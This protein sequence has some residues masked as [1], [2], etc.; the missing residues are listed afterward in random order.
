MEVKKMNY[1]PKLEIG[2][3]IVLGMVIAGI[4]WLYPEI[5]RYIKMMRM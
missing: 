1:S 2:A 4:V 3:L 5:K